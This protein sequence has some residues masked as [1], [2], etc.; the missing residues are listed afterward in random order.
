VRFEI[1]ERCVACMAC[2]RVC[3]TDAIAVEDTDVWIV[4]ETCVRT[5]LCLEAC[6]HDAI[7]VNGDLEQV[8]ALL[9]EGD[10]LLVLSAEAAVH[11]HP[12]TVEQIV[13]G[14]YAMGFA[15][16][17]HGT[18]GDELVAAEYLKLWETPQWRTLIRSTCPVLV[19][20]VRKD[21]PELVPYL[22]PVATPT[23]AEITYLHRAYPGQPIVYAG[24][25]LADAVEVADASV[26]FQ[27]LDGLYREYGVDLA[28]QP[29]FFRRIPG[30][31]RRHVSASG[32]LPLP[33]LLEEVQ[34]SRRFRKFRGLGALEM[35]Q[36]A[37]VE[38]QIDLGFV[39]ILPCEG[40]L[41]H[42]LL[43]PKDR[44]FWRRKI[45]AASEPPRSAVP[46]V[47]DVVVDVTRTFT[48]HGNGSHAP[49]ADIAAVIM[50]IGTAP[51]GA[52]WDCG[53]CGFATCREFASAVL[54]GRAGFRQ[55]PPYQERLAGEAKR[56]AAVDALTGLVTYRVLRD[57]LANEIA[58]SG[59]SGEP[60][61]VLFIDLDGFKQ[62]NDSFGHRAG[63]DVLS[64]VGQVLQKAVRG[65]DVAGRYGGDEFVVL[66]ARTDADG[67]HRVGE[68]IRGRVEAVGRGLGYADGA[69]TASIGVAEY[70]PRTGNGGDVLER[71]DK[72]LYRAKALGGNR[73]ET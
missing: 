59:R 38:D 10:A 63:S 44:L 40:C 71:A 22:A 69:V 34:A 5:G 29:S 48:F 3:P 19:E 58:R 55:C 47:D 30:E 35:I 51:S 60:F 62:I 32:G 64:A 33:V 18:I 9:A 4:E 67:A 72:A 65:T 73:I 37:V 43:G 23:E 52:P 57:R 45:A 15:G 36:Q 11:F 17:H 42:P 56:E 53:S 25:C 49:E 20:K 31:R 28:S 41:D 66:L 39:D 16:V 61:A 13:N 50:Q 21:Y 26:T 27:E 24:V 7:S 8:R 54:R 12:V 14:A 68:V 2:V 70:D 6:P 46:V 1:N